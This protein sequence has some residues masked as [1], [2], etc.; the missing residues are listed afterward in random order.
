VTA[1]RTGD[2][3]G[4]IDA[5]E[6]QAVRTERQLA[7]LARRVDTFEK[8]LAAQNRALGELRELAGRLVVAIVELRA[9][10]PAVE[11]F[12]DGG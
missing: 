10:L 6:K 9:G 4:R 1:S 5:L 7:A 11:E 12:R 8:A 2:A 3:G